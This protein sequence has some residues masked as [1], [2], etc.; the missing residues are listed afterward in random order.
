MTK[1]LLAREIPEEA[2]QALA[3]SLRIDPA[4]AL[5]LLLHM[6]AEVFAAPKAARRPRSRP[7][8]TN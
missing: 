3:A 2:I 6:Q 1:P 5:D 4:D 7:A 8:P